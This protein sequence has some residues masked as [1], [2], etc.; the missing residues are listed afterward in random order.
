MFARVAEIAPKVEKKAEL[1]KMVRQ[2]VLPILKRQPGFLELVPFV[3][4]S[5]PEHIFTIT[6]WTGKRDLERYVEEAFPIIEQILKPFLTI[7][8]TVRTYT[9]E[10]SVCKHLVEALTEAA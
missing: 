1:M 8:M 9:V 10:T 6:L 5:A 7:P 2:H 4:E 3:P